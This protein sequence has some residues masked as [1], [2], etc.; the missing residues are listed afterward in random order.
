MP[1]LEDKLLVT[2]LLTSFQCL[3][4]FLGVEIKHLFSILPHDVTLRI[5]FKG[6]GFNQFHVI[7]KIFPAGV[8][9]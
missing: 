8:L 3:I 4:V 5:V 2:D 7:I 6:V 9:P 1:D